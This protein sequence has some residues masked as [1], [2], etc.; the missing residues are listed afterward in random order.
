MEWLGIELVYWIGL[1][2]FA[3]LLFAGGMAKWVSSTVGFKFAWQLFRVKRSETQILVKV[4]MLNGKPKYIIKT[5]ANVI[6]YEYKENGQTKIGMVKY[7]QYAKYE[8]FS[9]IP[10]IEAHPHDILPRNPFIQSDMNIPGYILKKNIDDSSKDTTK[11]DDIKKLL[12]LA[13]PIVAVLVIGFVLWQSNQ[14]ETIADL[15]Q[16]VIELSKMIP[17]EA[18]VIA[19]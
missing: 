1:F 13:M 17:R 4:W 5:S 9:G 8:E 2:A 16:Q 10:V 11:G 6:E 14:A 3:C 15:T 19:E 7:D 12:K 18:T